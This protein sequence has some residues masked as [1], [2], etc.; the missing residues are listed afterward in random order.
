VVVEVKR[1]ALDIRYH[2]YPEN[3]GQ[4]RKRSNRQG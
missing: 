4:A 1:V 2:D 3:L